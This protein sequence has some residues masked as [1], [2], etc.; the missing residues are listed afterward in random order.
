MNLPQWLS[1]GRFLSPRVI[2]Y[3]VLVVTLLLSGLVAYNINLDI[4]GHQSRRFN[5]AVLQTLTAIEQRMATYADMLNSASALFYSSELVTRRE[6]QTYVNTVRVQERYPGIQS[7]GF[8]RRVHEFEQLAFAR[9][10]LE[11]HRTNP[12]GYPEF[13]IFQNHRRTE[14]FLIVFVEPIAQNRALFGRDMLAEPAC[15]A[16]MERARDTGEIAASERIM[17]RHG[18]KDEA[19]FVL[20]LPLYKPGIALDSVDNR[21]RALVG[22]VFGN[23]LM[24]DLFHGIFGKRVVSNLGI[25]LEVF[26]GRSL[27]REHLLYDD[28][29]VL[30][31]AEPNRA[32][33]HQR[34]VEIDVGGQTWSLFFTPLPAFHDDFASKLPILFFIVGALLSFLLFRVI[35]TRTVRANERR[36][37]TEMLE[38]QAKHDSLTDLPNRDFLLEQLK[39]GLQKSAGNP[40]NMA[41]LLIDLN[42][43]K[44]INDTLGHQSGDTLLQQIGPRLQKLLRPTDVLSRFGGDEFGLML[45]PLRGAEDAEI[46]AKRM[47]DEIHQPFEL[48]GITVQ[49]DAS[50][51][52]ALH[53][54]HGADGTTLMRC[55]DV[56]MYVAKK[57][58][59]GYAV[60][61]PELDMHS[62]RQ[63]SLMSQIEE[64]MRRE[65]LALYFQP[66][67]R[68]QDGNVIGVEALIRWHH[69]EEALIP[70]SEFIPQVERST[71]IRP[72]TLWVIEHALS[73]SRQ[74]QDA[75]LPTKVAVNISARNLLD[76]ELPDDVA[77]LLVKHRMTPDYLELEIT[78][79]AI[80]ADPERALD[81]LTQLHDRGVHISI[82]DFGTGYSSL[83]HLKKLPVSNLKIDA[84][85]V[86]DMTDDENDAII[87][88]STVDLSHNLGLN[89]IAEGVEDQETLD[90]LKVLDC[91]Y[92]QGFFI[93]RPIPAADVTE[94]LRAHAPKLRR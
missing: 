56:A 46:W 42:G 24:N 3:L 62:P 15:R 86:S 37:Y 89:V 35:L 52:I 9:Q 18:D 88:R 59:H 30:H 49:I 22:F 4:K 26:D 74:W 76:S 33:A 67:I 43:F 71:L 17:L 13:P 40:G 68:L 1:L 20:L 82:D 84:S 81:I 75:G 79:S 63:L 5:D 14:Y 94:W 69:P 6:F 65:Q 93:C 21:R 91:D 8:I 41:L 90:I 45:T 50:V 34:L 7:L 38:R 2:A 92:A 80:V 23:F 70:P 64:A 77:K 44:E 12:C 78:E 61:Q 53:P 73:Q 31:S 32:D 36:Q 83:A 11:E 25:D 51:G 85:F 29:A 19:G 48:D 28:D 54:L 55:A 87:V 47:I 60:Y 72:F 10:L 27:T 39:E 57:S 66:K 58:H 16:P